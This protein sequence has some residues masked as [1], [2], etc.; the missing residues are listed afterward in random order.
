MRPT[1]TAR[2]TCLAF[3][4]GAAAM[5]AVAAGP[6]AEVHKDHPLHDVM[7]A[8]QS[9]EA[10]QKMM[11]EWVAL[12][13]PTAAHAWLG[14]FV[15]EW[16]V[17]TETFMDPSGPPM[18]SSATSKTTWKLEGKWVEEE[19]HGD[20]M[21]MPFTGFSTCGF[22]NVRK[23]YVSTW[24]DSMGS[25]LYVSYG[26]VSPDMKTMTMFGTMDEPMTGEMGKTVMHQV[27][28]HSPDHHTF[29]MKEVI[30]GEPFTVMRMEY[31]RKKAMSDAGER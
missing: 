3:A 8:S 26:S 5:L 7:K 19:F 22:D 12:G 10:Q 13:E 16:D 20:M 1:R 30:Y 18:V 15:G 11:E 28:I 25:G 23:Q 27:T 6:P 21:G 24:I 17:K 4:A 31:H 2:V 29:E 9:P 14:H